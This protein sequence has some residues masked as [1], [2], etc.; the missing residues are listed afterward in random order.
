MNYKM[1]YKEKKHHIPFIPLITTIIVIVLIYVFLF[2]QL[3]FSLVI[4]NS[5]VGGG[6]TGSHNYIA[7]YAT[8]I[9]PKIKWW[10]PDWYA[11]F[12]FLYFY[13]PFLYY[14]VALANY[15]S[16]HYL[17]WNVGLKLA[18]VLG[19]LLL[20]LTVWGTGKVLRWK[21]PAPVL[22][23]VVSLLFLFCE[24]FSI[25][26]GN[27]PSTLAGEFSYS[28]AFALFWVWIAF[29]HRGLRENKYLLANIGIL[30][31]LVLSH[32]FSV[33]IAV[34]V[35][36]FYLIMSIWQK[37]FWYTLKYIIKVFGIAFCLTSFWSLPFLAY[38]PYT[39]KMSW[40][41]VV[42]L[43]ELFPS[44]LIFW[45]ILGLIGLLVSLLKKDT[46]VLPL[47]AV[48]AAAIIPYLFLNHSSIWNARFLPW[49]IFSLLM[50][51]AYFIGNILAYLNNNKKI[52]RKERVREL[53]VSILV[54]IVVGGILY[55]QLPAHISYIPSWW[56]WNYEGIEKKASWPEL[57]ALMLYLKKLPPG[58]IMWE[59]RGEYDRF[60][61]PRILEDIPIWT[62]HPTFEGLLIESGIFSYFHFI[63]QAETTRTP[64]SAVAGF[65]YPPFDFSRGV[66]HLQLSGARY[67]VAYTTDVKK[68]ANEHFRKL[69]DIQGFSVYEVPNSN[70]V[71]ILDDWVIKPKTKH[72]IEQS[73]EW[74]K[75]DKLQTP[76]IFYKNK[77]EKR[78]LYSLSHFHNSQPSSVKIVSEEG[79]KLKFSTSALGRPHL[80]K[81]SYF[82]GWRVKGA[83]GPFLVSPSFM[84]VIPV[85]SEVTLYYDYTILDRVAFV[86]SALTLLFLLLAQFFQ[87][88]KNFLVA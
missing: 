11:G 67:F 41:K 80:V 39:A 69:K 28:F 8:Q 84:V 62:G 58:R 65:H 64:T 55:K 27:L 73:I 60:G 49:I 4:E 46:K 50:A 57:Q 37:K 87:K 56:K 74:Y 77:R 85:Q 51:A 72:W 9:F 19:T 71:Q 70:L 7:Y 82:P 24:A 52:I 17:P 34:G 21:Y 66:R 1:S 61:T 81:I 22:A 20:P 43:G 12:P 35:A 33:I 5:T 54:L 63:N 31:L 86:I 26:G 2:S 38:L 48:V 14:L 10:S 75:G 6:D 68:L 47:V 59:Y 40:T 29:F 88:L 42:K 78:I 79:D 36:S 3:P 16:P 13:P 83:Q 18:T 15:F 25:Y 44:S 23:A 53:A 32:P 30:S 45:E 76:M